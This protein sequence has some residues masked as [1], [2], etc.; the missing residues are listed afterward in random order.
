[1]SGKMTADIFFKP[2]LVFFNENLTWTREQ[3]HSIEGIL[4]KKTYLFIRLR[5]EKMW[6]IFIPELYFAHT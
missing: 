4:N 6:I 5:V 2:K 1:M 3:A